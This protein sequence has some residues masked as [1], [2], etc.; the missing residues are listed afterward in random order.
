MSLKITRCLFQGETITILFVVSPVLKFLYVVDV[1]QCK[2]PG[3]VKNPE[4]ISF[5]A[6]EE[7]K[8]CL[9]Y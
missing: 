6:E 2:F 1:L 5:H 7:G 3:R 9:K 4:I 8:V